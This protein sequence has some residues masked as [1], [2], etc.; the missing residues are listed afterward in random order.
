MSDY[1]LSHDLYGEATS[2]RHREA[3]ALVRS[4]SHHRAALS[5]RCRLRGANTRRVR[6]MVVAAPTVA[7]IVALATAL[8]G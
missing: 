4:R 1:S 7:L 8:I 6:V 3:D 2:R 5:A